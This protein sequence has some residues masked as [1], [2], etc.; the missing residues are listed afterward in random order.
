VFL[1]RALPLL[2]SAQRIAP[3]VGLVSSVVLIFFGVV[4]ITDNF[5]VPSS[6]LYR[7]YLGL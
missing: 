7:L 3:V 2:N 4:L 6:A 5:H 1:S